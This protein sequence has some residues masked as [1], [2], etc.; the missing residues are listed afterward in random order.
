[1]VLEIW[2]ELTFAENVEAE[3]LHLSATDFHPPGRQTAGP[4]RL[5]TL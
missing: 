5:R 4:C 3:E 1:M 2:H